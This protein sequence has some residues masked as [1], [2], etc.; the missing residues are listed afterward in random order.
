MARV[1]DQVP[2]KLGAK[3]ITV[4][5]AVGAALP[6][7]VGSSCSQTNPNAASSSG[8]TG[9]NGAACATPQMGCPCSVGQTAKCGKTVRSDDHFVWCFEGTRTCEP[10]GVWGDCFDGS[11]SKKTILTLPNGDH[12]IQTLAYGSGGQGVCPVGSPDGGPTPPG[13][14]SCDPYCNYTGDT[15]PGVD[16]QAPFI[17]TDGVGLTLPLGGSPT[18]TGPVSAPNGV[19]ACGGAV[20]VIGPN[21][22]PGSVINHSVCQQDHRCNVATST[23]IWNGSNGYYDP[24]AGGVDLTLGAACEYAGTAI[25]PVCNRGS[26]AVPAGTTIGINISNTVE[27]GCTAVH[28]TPDCSDVTPTGGLP[29]GVCMNIGGCAISGNE[30]AV[31]NASQRDIAE[32][33][34][35][36]NAAAAKV[37]GAPGCAQCGSCDT[38]ITGTIYDPSGRSSGSNPNGNDVRL[39]NIHIFQPVPGTLIPIPDVAAPACDTCASLS[40]PEYS[41]D[42]SA[43][44]GTF[45]IYNAVPGPAQTLV[46]QSGRWRREFNVGAVPAC[47]TTTVTD[48]DARMPRNTTDGISVKMPR[49]AM[50]LGSKETL[51][52]LF[53]RIGISDSEFIAPTAG[54]WNTTTRRFHLY[55]ST[56]MQ[57]DTAAGLNQLASGAPTLWGDATRL[58]GYD[59]VIGS[60]DG[61]G[62]A[63]A[64]LTGGAGGD[65][66]RLRNYA[67]AGGRLFVDHWAA[68]GITRGGE[69]PWQDTAVIAS[70][71]PGADMNG[72][73]GDE[74]SKARV[75]NTTPAQQNLYGFLQANNAMATFG[76]PY[77]RLD[78]PKREYLVAGSGVTEYVRGLAGWTAAGAD[79]WTGTPGGSHSLSFSFDTPLGAAATCG[80]VIANAMHVSQSRQS[81]SDTGTGD[82]FPSA[83]GGYPGPGGNLTAEEKALEYQLFQLTACVGLTPSSPPPSVTI[84]LPQ[85][86]EFYR[87]FEGICPPG[88]QV[89]WQLFEWQA[90]VP[91]GA[92][93]TFRA[94]TAATPG[95]FAA[96]PPPAA[97]GSVFAGEANALNSPMPL[98]RIGP[99]QWRWDTDLLNTPLPVSWHLINDPPGPAQTSREWLRIYMT[100]RT[101][102]VFAPTLYEWRQL[103]DCIPNE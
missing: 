63:W 55:R 75:L 22:A 13:F 23:C 33:R 24:G 87:D 12:A 78:Q 69:P 73:A 70:N 92:S 49:V 19:S 44:N 47:Q 81:G 3:I 20:N 45:T 95:A 62:N 30:N 80:K 91:I 61:S 86:A 97:P 17:F 52:C 88:H 29:P 43:A 53:R 90:E 103:Y 65:L 18:P 16:A 2:T 39:G 7:L 84:P 8:T 34:C 102:G 15:A 77:V 82:K 76:A 66:E 89:K 57:T 67:N 100:F 5:I 71:A 40:S 83:C 35:M 31:V 46:V 60:C 14:D 99:I 68:D 21:C 9:N 101:N 72:W 4:F 58:G 6:M 74:P 32:P 48:G 27:D 56:G 11:V 79:E 50:V 85:T 93:I 41:F 25:F 59:A 54:D 26:V 51:E 28:P 94:S 37:N 98:L 42:T 96:P 38:R 10:N 1:V 36:N 64:N